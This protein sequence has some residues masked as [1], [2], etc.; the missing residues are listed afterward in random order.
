MSDRII[1]GLGAC[2]NSLNQVIGPAVEKTGDSLAREQVALMAKYLEFVTQRLN[3]SRDRTRYELQQYIFMGV[4]IQ[5]L[6]SAKNIEAEILSTHTADAKLCLNNPDATN[7]ELD[8]AS[9]LLKAEI[10]RITR[11]LRKVEPELRKLIE[12]VIHK[13]SRFI[14]DIRRAW[15]KP[16]NWES[17]KDAV[18]ELEAILKTA[19]TLLRTL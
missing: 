15:C 14:V 3:L 12:Q 16:Q 7:Q 18:P 19:S 8:D 11:S 6:F 17:D 2:I 10:S 5:S 4:E 9:V 1:N 13:Y